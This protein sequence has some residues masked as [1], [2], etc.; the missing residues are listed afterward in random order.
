MS[1][2]A[3]KLEAS[4]FNDGLDPLAGYGGLISTGLNSLRPVGTANDGE[5]IGVC[6]FISSVRVIPPIVIDTFVIPTI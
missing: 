5:A 6:T 1:Y 4:C 2:L 3:L